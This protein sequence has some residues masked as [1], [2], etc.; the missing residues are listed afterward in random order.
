MVHDQV[1]G[2]T[3]DQAVAASGAYLVVVAWVDGL[4]SEVRSAAVPCQVAAGIAAAH[5]SLLRHR[6]DHRCVIRACPRGD[7]VDCAGLCGAAH[8]DCLD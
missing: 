1:A 6:S 3:R 8:T 2:A 7:R 5:V 4:P